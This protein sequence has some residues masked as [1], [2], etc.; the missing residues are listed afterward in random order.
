[1]Y[2]ITNKDATNTA[3]TAFLTVSSAIDAPTVVLSRIITGDSS[4]S[5]RAS[6]ISAVS[7]THLTLPTK[8]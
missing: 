3:I 5:F 1:M 4:S 7:Y 2:V 8:A 6:L